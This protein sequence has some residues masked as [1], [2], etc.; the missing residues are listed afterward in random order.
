MSNN[1][2][3]D[4]LAELQDLVKGLQAKFPNGQFTLENTALTTPA[5]VG[6]IQGL[7]DAINGVNTAET[8]VKAAQQNARVKEANVRPIV[9]ALKRNLR[10]MFGQAADQLAPFGLEPQ[11]A[12][13]PR[14]GKQVV[15]AAAKA[16]ATRTARGTTSKKQK[17]E[18]TGNVTGVQVT[19]ITAPT[20]AEPA[21][22]APTQPTV[23]PAKP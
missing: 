4:T 6:L 7:I 23:T 13:K 21:A 2:K 3:A 12:P 14:T 16:E 19:P 9:T 15:A 17:L 10:A 20:P 18:V 5:L 22:P 11:K 8:A 1:S